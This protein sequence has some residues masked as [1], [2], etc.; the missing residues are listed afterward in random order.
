MTFRVVDEFDPPA[1][2]LWDTRWGT[3]PSSPTFGSG[4]WRLADPAEEEFN[5]GGLAAADPLTT[6]IILCLF[7]DRRLADWMEI[8]DDG[9]RG[10]H[11]DHFA[12][13]AEAG[14]R[15]LGSYLW[16]LERGALDF[17]TRKLAE[18]YATEALQTLIDQGVVSKIEVTAEADTAAGRLLIN[19][20]CYDPARDLLADRRFEVG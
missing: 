11:G 6:A 18:T 1:S 16:T 3:D 17:Q 5:R 14:E 13:D 10:W 15:E 20:R 4:D 12:I 2:P 9:V 19:V 7:T 8:G